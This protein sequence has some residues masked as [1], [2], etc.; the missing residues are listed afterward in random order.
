LAI[1]VPNVLI[2]VDVARVARCTS[3]RP[4]CTPSAIRAA[5]M[6]T[7]TMAVPTAAIATTGFAST[8]AVSFPKWR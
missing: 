6:A 8:N 2:S 5:L 3:S 1:S 4:R 7:P